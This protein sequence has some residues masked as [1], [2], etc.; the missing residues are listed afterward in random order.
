MLERDDTCDVAVVPLDGSDWPRRVSH[1]DY[2]WDP[3]WSADG[4]RVA[5]HEWDLPNMPW[6]GSRIMCVAP[7]REQDARCVAGGDDVAVG[8]PRFSPTGDTLAFV[9]EAGGWMNVWLA[10]GD[11]TAPAPLVDDAHEHAE[12]SWGP[13]QRSFAWSPD[14]T[15]IVLNRNEDGFGRLVLVDLADRSPV[16]VSRGWHAGLDWGPA[17]VACIRSG[18]RTAPQLTVLDPRTGART[19]RARGAPAELDAVDLPEPTPVSWSGVD[20]EP[21]HGLL[22]RPT[23]GADDNGDTLPPLLVD[24]HGGPTDQS[25][26]DWKPR[27]RYFVSRGWA[28]LQPNY[29]GSTGY[30]RG[31]RHALDHEWGVVDVADTVAGIQAAERGGWAD[32]S[33][34][35]VMGGSAGGFTALL[36]AAQTP[37]VVRAVV[38]LFGV[39]DLFDLAATTHRFE[40]RYLD[41]LV[42]PLP[43]AA[44]QYRTRSP[45][46]HAHGITV[47]A[48]VLQ[49]ADDKVVPPAQAQLL[50]DSMRTAG[51]AVEHHV[52]DGEGHGFSKVETIVDSLDRIDRFLT[53]WVVQ[54]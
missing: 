41:R 38:S 24:V 53:K 12:P 50:V 22:W 51:A 10:P 29:R 5:W 32:A 33:R 39:T 13:G 26:V 23:A 19:S 1:A 17:G 37:P 11:G 25:T 7:D 46:A 45:V 47:P 43:A 6:D 31:Y 27:V 18:G 36:V 28:V 14:G 54:R 16:D 48:L 21:V 44:E 42:G 9:S 15:A 3:A 2:A 40:S 20:G 8:Q 4:T 52:Y 49:G 35:A 30:G 34:A